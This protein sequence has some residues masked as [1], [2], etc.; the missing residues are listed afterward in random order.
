L[1][2]DFWDETFKITGVDHELTLDDILSCL[3]CSDDRI[4]DIYDIIKDDILDF[5][6]YLESI[7]INYLIRKNC[8]CKSDKKQRKLHPDKY[9]L[10]KGQQ[11]LLP[12]NCIEE[13]DDSDLEPIDTDEFDFDYE[14]IDLKI[15]GISHYK[16]LIRQINFSYI[17]HAYD[18]C[19]VILRRLF[20]NL[21]IEF[22]EVQE[23][24]SEITNDK[25]DIF[26]MSLLVSRFLS[27]KEHKPGR[28][29]RTILDIVKDIGDI[30]AHSRRTLVR[31]KEII[32]NRIKIQDSI[33]DILGLIDKAKSK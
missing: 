30:G 20:E 21:I 2:S 9:G 29:T 28:N 27:E 8:S 15:T 6:E 11:Y 13:I 26:P 25:G 23:R 17:V 1:T 5:R 33:Q 16:K 10:Y 14:L 7:L 18:A 22:F 24:V 3:F 12:T 31:K 32:E 4:S 19:A